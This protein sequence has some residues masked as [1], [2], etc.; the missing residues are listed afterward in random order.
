MLDHQPLI[1]LRKEGWESHNFLN[2]KGLWRGVSILFHESEMVQSSYGESLVFE[3][4]TWANNT[5]YGQKVVKTFGNMVNGSLIV[6]D[7][8]TKEILKVH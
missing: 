5:F 3:D 7:E 1:V 2:L 6:L 8:E 4:P